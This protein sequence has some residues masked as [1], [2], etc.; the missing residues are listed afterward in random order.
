MVIFSLTIAGIVDYVIEVARRSKGRFGEC[1][2][3]LLSGR[4]WFVDLCSHPYEVPPAP[5]MRT[6]PLP[7]ED[8]DTVPGGAIHCQ[9]GQ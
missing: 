6:I 7:P 1:S 3:S 5:R 9:C 4:E 8:E 2:D